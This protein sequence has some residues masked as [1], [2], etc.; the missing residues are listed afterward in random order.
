[1]APLPLRAAL[2]LLVHTRHG[3]TC[4]R[5]LLVF[6]GPLFCADEANNNALYCL[7]SLLSGAASAELLHRLHSFAVPS[8]VKRFV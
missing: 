1:M 6:I 3:T 7:L 2:Q 5:Q 4:T 8:V